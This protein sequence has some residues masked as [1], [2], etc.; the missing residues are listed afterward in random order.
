MNDSVFSVDK[1]EDSLGLLLWQTTITWQRK[2]KKALDPYNVSHAQFVILAVTLWFDGQGQDVSQSLI[3]Q[4]SKL[5][6]MTV[7]KSL[8]L[9]VAAGYIKREEH[10]QDTRVKLVRLT[11]KGRELARKLVPI[12][13]KID[14][15]F[16]SA[17]NKNDQKILIRIL[18]K[19]I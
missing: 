19:L 2:I 6:K 8:K 16:F 12:V 15:N 4:Q 5:D 14:A 13:E 17:V 1:A 11:S 9:L 10:K 18:N 7:S 3:I